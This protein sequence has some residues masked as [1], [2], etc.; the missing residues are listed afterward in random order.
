MSFQDAY[1]AL[2][3]RWNVPVDHLDLAGTH[4]LACGP[5]DAPP[6][7]LLAGHG[8]TAPVWFRLAPHLAQTH[9]V[10]APDLPGDA[11]FS[12]AP[13][14]RTP[15]DVVTWLSTVVG[16]LTDPVLVGHSYGAWIALT[17]AL[18]SPVSRLVLLDPT[19]CFTALSPTYV[20]R[21]LPLLIRPSER[22]HTAFL[23]WETQGLPLDPDWLHLSALAAV[24]PTTK[25]V[26]PHRPKPAALKTLPPTTVVIPDRTKA[27]NP[28]ALAQAAQTAGA[29]TTHI[30]QATHHSLPTLHTPALLTA[31]L[32]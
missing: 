17:Y 14:P 7:V 6:M 5:A 2:V 8:A 19:D 23:T 28:Q 12:T 18:Q 30:P 32:P 10:Y 25:P 16:D 22:R 1:D 15:S 9:R 31:L 4:V 24:Q 26:R 21:A 11:G 20:A 27:H 13:P 3:T 29:T